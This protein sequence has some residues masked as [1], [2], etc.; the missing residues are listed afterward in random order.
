MG[1][2]PLVNLDKLTYA[3][4]RA[5]LASDEGAAGYTF[6]EGD[7]STRHWWRGCSTSTRR[8][9]V[10]ETYN[11]G[12]GNQRTN[13]QVVQMLCALLDELVLESKFR[14]HAQLIRHVENRP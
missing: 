7:I 6:V 10:G 11:V 2:G 5:N 8:G 4:N 3:G 9:R 12:G 13:M 1:A 14:P